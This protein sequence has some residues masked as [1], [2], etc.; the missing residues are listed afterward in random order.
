MNASRKAGLVSLSLAVLILTP[1]SA[2]GASSVNVEVENMR[3][4][5]AN[6]WFSATDP[7]GCVTTE[8]FVSATNTTDQ[9]LPG[10]GVTTPIAAVSIFQYDTCTGET[11]LDAVGQTD[12][13]GA[14]DFQ[15]ATQLDAAVLRTAVTMTDVGTGDTFDVSVDIAW[16]GTSEI[17]RQHSNTNEVFPGCHVLNRWKGSGRQASASGTVLRGVTNFTPAASYL[18]EI[19]Y[20]IDGFEVIGCF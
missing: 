12:T 11:L 8:T 10:P 9:H 17:T 1:L 13:L 3:G 2:V 15:V 14:D 6:A 4:P 5:L 20:V 7:S 19:G 16:T 18:A